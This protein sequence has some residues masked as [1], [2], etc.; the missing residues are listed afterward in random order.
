MQELSGW[1]SGGVASA[2]DHHRRLRLQEPGDG[3]RD[4]ESD[5]QACD[6]QDRDRTIEIESG[7]A[8]V[9][10]GAEDRGAVHVPGEKG[11]VIR[12]PGE[13]RGPFHHAGED[14]SAFHASGEERNASGMRERG[15]STVSIAISRG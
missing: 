1:I 11:D 10:P 3:F 2:E 13:D 15:K 12:M 6:A 9:A 14:R 8:T 5:R 7:S 4:T